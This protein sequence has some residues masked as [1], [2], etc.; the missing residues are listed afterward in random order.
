MAP[1]F[2]SMMEKH[3]TVMT[4]LQSSGFVPVVTAIKNKCPFTAEALL[5]DL[6]A[7]YCAHAHEYSTEEKLIISRSIDICWRKIDELKEAQEE[8]KRLPDDGKHS[9]ADRMPEA[10]V[11]LLIYCAENDDSVGGG[12]A[13][14]GE[15]GKWYWT[16]DYKLHE[17]CKYPVT[18][19]RYL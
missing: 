12:A 8:L 4:A 14:L 18:H 10:G 19:W 1:R 5:M 2:D 3:L 15:D 9:V 16:Y 7:D 17:E 13:A 11:Q 6:D